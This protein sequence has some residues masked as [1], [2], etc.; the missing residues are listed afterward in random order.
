ML[1]VQSTYNEIATDFD[2]TRI[3]IWSCVK[4]F[5][6]SIPNKESKR[7]LDAGCG[8]GKNT[9]FIFDSGF[10]DVF[11]IDICE[12]FVEMSK[13]YFKWN[14]EYAIIQGDLRS[15][16]YENSSFNHV[17]S[18]AV[19]HHLTT[20]QDRKQCIDELIRITKPSGSILITV[21]SKEEPFY[22]KKVSK[23][24]LIDNFNK[25]L[26]IDEFGDAMVPWKNAKG[27]LLGSRYYH[28]FG[29]EELLKLCIN[30]RI[31]SIDYTFEMSNHCIILNLL[32]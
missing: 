20:D 15:T 11:A 4:K 7:I 9:K 21:C 18:I 23:G 31:S 26:N 14:R 19:I 32:K 10:V 3:M 12:S 17:I 5:I 8:N 24:T 6:E 13:K 29:K 2:K 25:T 30:E 22:I 28:F 16:P 27:E 1:N